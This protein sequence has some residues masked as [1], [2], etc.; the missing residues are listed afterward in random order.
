MEINLHRNLKRDWSPF[1][2]RQVDYFLTPIKGFLEMVELNFYSTHSKAVKSE[3][4]CCE[5]QCVSANGAEFQI[6]TKNSDGKAAVIGC[7]SRMRRELMR[8]GRYYF[9]RKKI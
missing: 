3:C 9:L 8:S 4:Y 5:I 6:K 2:T 1:I 7:L